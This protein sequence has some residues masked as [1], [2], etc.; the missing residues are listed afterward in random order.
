MQTE[1]REQLFVERASLVRRHPVERCGKNLEA[2]LMLHALKAGLQIE[3]GAVRADLLVLV[4]CA[5]ENELVMHCGDE[6][7][8]R[9]D[10]VKPMEKRP[11]FG[12]GVI[13]GLRLQRRDVL[14]TKLA[15]GS[16]LPSCA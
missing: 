15:H 13:G 7:R 8:S 9:I 6:L 16:I 10:L 14:P 1:P 4:G 5:L 3:R 2:A 12:A 11:H